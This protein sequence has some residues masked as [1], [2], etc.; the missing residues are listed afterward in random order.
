MASVKCQWW[1]Q[2]HSCEPKRTF[3]A[4]VGWRE[5]NRHGVTLGHL[6]QDLNEE[7]DLNL[8]RLLKKSVQSSCTFGFAQ[9]A[10]PLFNSTQF[11]FEVLVQC[12]SSHLLQGCLIL[13]DI[14]NP[15]LSSSVHCIIVAALVL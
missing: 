15:L 7:T 2:S 14:R 9:N 10:E 3:L 5:N 8:G 13:I 1:N 4:E 12:S 11:I 6:L